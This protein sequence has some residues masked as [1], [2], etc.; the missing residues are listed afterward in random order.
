MSTT[1][2]DYSNANISIGGEIQALSFEHEQNLRNIPRLNI[3]PLLIITVFNYFNFIC[4]VKEKFA[5]DKFKQAR[6]LIQGPCSREKRTDLSMDSTPLKP[7]YREFFS[8]GRTP[9]K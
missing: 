2:L 1:I 4:G 7:K 5:P 3:Y 9:E 8:S 6:R